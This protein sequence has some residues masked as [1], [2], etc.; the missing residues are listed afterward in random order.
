M[1]WVMP[2]KVKSLLRIYREPSRPWICLRGQLLEWL[3]TSHTHTHAHTHVPE[4][5]KVK[6]FTSETIAGK[7]SSLSDVI[8][9][10]N[11]I[12]DWSDKVTDRHSFL[13]KATCHV[14][15]CHCTDWNKTKVSFHIFC[16][17]L[18]GTW[19]LYTYPAVKIYAY[20]DGTGDELAC[21][22]V[23]Y[24]ESRYRH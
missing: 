7:R 17:S 11:T 4:V 15:S 1:C 5:S 3:A 9:I 10:T 14:M 24:N 23:N 13:C 18:F 22:L 20:V 2:R 6:G 8:A 21:L 19:P 12:E 16:F